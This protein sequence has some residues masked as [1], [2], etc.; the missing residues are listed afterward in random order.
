MN[1]GQS[2]DPSDFVTDLHLGKGG[3]PVTRCIGADDQTAHGPLA[4]S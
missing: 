3:H 4:E 2:H 1:G